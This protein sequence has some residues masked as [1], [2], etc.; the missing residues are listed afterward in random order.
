MCVHSGIV[1]LLH[2]AQASQPLHGKS[3]HVVQENDRSLY[4]DPQN[5]KV[6]SVDR[7]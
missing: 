4:W 1:S 3:V 6:H 7:M 2:N 5:A